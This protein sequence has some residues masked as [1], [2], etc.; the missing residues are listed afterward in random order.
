MLH[1]LK[2]TAVQLWLSLF[3]SGLSSLWVLPL[4]GPPGDAMQTAA[5]TAAVLIIMFLI[6][7]WIMNLFG[8]RAIQQSTAS[9]ME[10]AR[11]GSVHEAEAAYQKVV[12]LFDS[13][14]LSPRLRKRYSRQ[15]VEQLA[16]FYLARADRAL[17][18]ERFIVSHLIMQ[19]DD[20]EAAQT[21]LNQAGGRGW[22]PESYL[23]LAARIGNA[24]PRNEYIQQLLARFYIA[25]ER[26]D[27]EALQTYRRVLEKKGA[28]ASNLAVR[29]ASI[30]LREG[31]ADEWAMRVYIQALQNDVQDPELLAG[32]AACMYWIDETDQNRRLFESARQAIAGEDPVRL[33]DMRG[34]FTTPGP[35]PPPE[36]SEDERQSGAA[37]FTALWRQMASVFEACAA[38]VGS[39]FGLARKAIHLFRTSAGFRQ[40]VQW[41]LIGAVVVA[42]VVLVINTADYLLK[43]E[44]DGEEKTLTFPVEGRFTVQVAAYLKPEHAERFMAQLREKGLAAYWIRTKRGNKEWYQV[45]VSRF[46]NKESARAYGESLK[47]QGI[48]EDFYIANFVPP[49]RR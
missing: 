13:S 28:P 47:G 45:R 32:I 18:S 3:I 42:A 20:R 31:R 38:G 44:S 41:G 9:A 25:E 7:G 6:V 11:T 4:V 27:Y 10:L 40:A 15:T 21:W 24:Q 19:P 39:I 46:P 14:L 33:T 34:R 48:I 49:A 2:H 35:E 30:L 16:R 23:E 26:T 36:V 8:E 1:T 37:A 43:P 5:V 22:L 12:S 29:L 17:E